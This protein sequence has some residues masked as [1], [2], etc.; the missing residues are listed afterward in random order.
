[1]SE[2]DPFYP[3]G[4]QTLPGHDPTKVRRAPI[5]PSIDEMRATANEDDPDLVPA[6]VEISDAE[7]FLGISRSAVSVC[8]FPG[9]VIISGFTYG[10]EPVDVHLDPAVAREFAAAIVRAADAAD[11]GPSPDPTP[12]P[13]AGMRLWV[14]F[15]EGAREITSETDFLACTADPKLNPLIV[16]AEDAHY[17][18]RAYL[19]RGT[20]SRRSFTVRGTQYSALSDWRGRP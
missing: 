9:G 4:M 8:H 6:D 13:P 19:L 11:G 3:H 20:V 2:S 16:D 17:A 7:D 1:M 12:W 15:P 5:V 14:A 18:N 10:N